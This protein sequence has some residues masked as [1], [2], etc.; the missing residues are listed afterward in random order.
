MSP[1]T[2]NCTPVTVLTPSETVAVSW[3]VPEI[4]APDAGEVSEIESEPDA[5]FTVKVAAEL[6]ML[7]A[8]LLTTTLK[9]DPLSPE[10]VAGVV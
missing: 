2:W 8:E 9:L 7:P 10:V 1:S 6:V 3:I 4:D 5:E